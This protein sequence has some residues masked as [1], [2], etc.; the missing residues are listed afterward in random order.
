[1]EV[2]C[3]WHEKI[4][5]LGSKWGKCGWQRNLRIIWVVTSLIHKLKKLPLGKGLKTGET[6]E[7]TMR[8]FC[9]VEMK[10]FLKQMLHFRLDTVTPPTWPGVYEKPEELLFTAGRR[11]SAYL[12]LG[13]CQQVYERLLLL[14]NQ[15]V[16]RALQ[17]E[18]NISASKTGMAI[19]WWP[20][21]RELVGREEGCVSPLE[22]KAAP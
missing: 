10:G 16:T 20:L 11:H 18:A 9:V 2:D 7:A 15:N 22:K 5:K 14:Q 8:K 6:P 17:F 19:K 13:F 4:R 3:I 12:V 1:M 21:E